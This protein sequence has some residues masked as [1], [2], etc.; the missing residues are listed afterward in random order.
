MQRHCEERSDEATKNIALGLD[1][2]PGTAGQMTDSRLRE[3]YFEALGVQ[4]NAASESS[5]LEAALK[6]AHEIRQFELDLYWKRATYFWALEGAVFAA[7][8]LLW[9]DT[10]VDTRLLAV[11]PAIAG[12]GDHAKHGGGGAGEASLP[13]RFVARSA[14]PLPRF[15]REDESAPT[16][17]SSYM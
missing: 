9:R 14:V 15:A 4:K 6:R 5:K 12:E 1:R 7:F 16:L 8:A 11:A 3:K 13:P 10:P 2:T 17:I